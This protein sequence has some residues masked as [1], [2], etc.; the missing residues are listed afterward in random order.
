MDLQKKT[1][2]LAEELKCIKALTT[3][4]E[5]NKLVDSR[6]LILPYK[7]PLPLWFMIL[8]NKVM[9]DDIIRTTTI[10]LMKALRDRRIGK[11]IISKLI[12]QSY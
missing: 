11:Q 12:R 8:T 1:L 7:I 9:K 10:N 3:S 2:K 5:I 6:K 4:M